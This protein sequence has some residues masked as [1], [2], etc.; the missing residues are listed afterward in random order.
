M[1]SLTSM[2]AV[3]ST[4]SFPSR[5]ESRLY[6]ICRQPR[7]MVSVVPAVIDT[8]NVCPRHDDDVRRTAPAVIGRAA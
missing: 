6:R 3:S 7:S 2:L 8:T 1:S 5:P 4:R